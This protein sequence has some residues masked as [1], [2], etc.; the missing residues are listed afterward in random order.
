M[1]SSQAPKLREAITVVWALRNLQA[2]SWKRRG[3]Q[4]R[5]RHCSTLGRAIDHLDE[6]ITPLQLELLPLDIGT[7]G[8]ALSNSR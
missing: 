2:R 8:H 4:Q 6:N 1:R 5:A 3:Q 7:L